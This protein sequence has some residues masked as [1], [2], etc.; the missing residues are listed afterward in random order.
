MNDVSTFNRCGRAGSQYWHI[1]LEYVFHGVFLA[2]AARLRHPT[3]EGFSAMDHRRV[4]HEA[5]VR[6]FIIP[7]KL[8]DLKSPFRKN[9]A[10]LFVLGTRKG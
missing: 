7:R 10:I 2:T 5:A 8:D 6:M 4:F 3:N 1:V 9:L